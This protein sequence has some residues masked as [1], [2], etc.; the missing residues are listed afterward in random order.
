M[1]SAAQ[2]RKRQRA[3]AARQALVLCEAEL[4]TRPRTSAAAARAALRAA[5]LPPHLAA[6]L[7]N[8]LRLIPEREPAR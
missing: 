8:R 5:G 4:I 6:T 1:T 2:A 3:S 7:R